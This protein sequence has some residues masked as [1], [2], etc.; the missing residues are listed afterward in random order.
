MILEQA[1]KALERYE[2]ARQEFEKV[3]K[4]AQVRGDALSKMYIPH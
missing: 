2:N 1:R 4:I 3:Q